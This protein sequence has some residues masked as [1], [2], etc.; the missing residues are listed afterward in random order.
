MKQD[1][2]FYAG[3]EEEVAGFGKQLRLRAPTTLQEEI[4]ANVGDG[5]EVVR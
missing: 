2:A 1:A 5:S 3:T 4:V